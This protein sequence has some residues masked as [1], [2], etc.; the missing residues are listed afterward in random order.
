MFRK[1][2]LPRVTRLKT[3]PSFR[4][5]SIHLDFAPDLQHDY[6]F[7]PRNVLSSG[8]TSHWFHYSSFRWDPRKTNRNQHGSQ[9]M[10]HSREKTNET[11][12]A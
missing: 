12:H 11:N 4:G 2:F 8:Q 1:A 9:K 6:W 7:W 3:Y 10:D 5:V